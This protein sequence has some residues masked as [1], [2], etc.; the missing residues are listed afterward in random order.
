[1]VF[2]TEQTDIVIK[3]DKKAEKE[4]SKEHSYWRHFYSSFDISV[5]SQFCVSVATEID[6]ECPVV[7]F[8]C[9]NGRDS[10]YLARLGFSVFAGDICSD[11][12][13]TN[14][15]KE[16]AQHHPVTFQIC[17]VTN[18]DHVASL[19]DAARVK[20]N[21]GKLTLYNRFFLHSLNDEQEQSFLTTLSSVSNIGDVLYLEFRCSLD[22][23][24]DKVYGKGHYRRYVRTEELVD[25]LE[26]LHFSVNYSV[27]GQGMAKFKS[28]DPFVSRIIAAKV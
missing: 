25:F 17:D 2:A 15:H 28:E 19:I 6:K 27:T 8:G 13:R 23:N 12:I 3:I 18:E 22:E 21:G 16:Q 9:G 7:E 1:M 26:S 20:A 11:A 24:L 4:T 14:T 10:I 5:P